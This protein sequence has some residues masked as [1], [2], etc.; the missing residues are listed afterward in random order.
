MEEYVNCSLKAGI[1]R[2]RVHSSIAVYWYTFSSCFY[3]YC[4]PNLPSYALCTQLDNDAIV[5]GAEEYLDEALA[6][7]VE[8]PPALLA[9]V[10][11]C[12][13]GLIGDDVEAIARVMREDFL[14][15]NECKSLW[16][17]RRTSYRGIAVERKY[18]AAQANDSIKIT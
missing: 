14:R 5:F 16:G 2:K 6:P 1:K 15:I 13:A 18:F 11:R 3:I 8:Q 4:N 17:I 10:S 7:Y 9:I 12:A